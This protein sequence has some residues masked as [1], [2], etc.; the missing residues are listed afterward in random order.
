MINNCC[1]AILYLYSNGRGTI[2]HWT[3]GHCTEGQLGTEGNWAPKDNWAPKTGNC[4]WAPKQNF[5]K[6]REFQI[7]WD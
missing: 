6:T 3:V 2:G 1:Q 4:N 5:Q 7:R